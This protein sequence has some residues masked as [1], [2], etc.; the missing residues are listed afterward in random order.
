MPPPPFS[1]PLGII[2]AVLSLALIIWLLTNVD[3]LK[4]GITVGIMVGI[5][6]V[7]YIAN[8]LWQRRNAGLDLSGREL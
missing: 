3:F 8:R 6:L 5:G 1:A 2:S 7:I 4:E